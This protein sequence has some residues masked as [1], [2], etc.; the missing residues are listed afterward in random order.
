MASFVTQNGAAV[1]N[2]K[3]RTDIVEQSGALGPITTPMTGHAEEGHSRDERTRATI[4]WDAMLVKDE[5]EQAPANQVDELGERALEAMGFALCK[6]FQV[7]WVSTNRVPFY[8]TRGL[9]NA[10]NANREVKIAQDG[11]QLEPSIGKSLI[12][13]FH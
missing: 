7:K 12:Q 2:S 11:A 9:R 6:S 13:L 8:R 5:G 4:F 3:T 1:F 10:W